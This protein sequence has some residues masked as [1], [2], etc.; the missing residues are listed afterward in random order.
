MPR[1]WRLG[2]YLVVIAAVFALLPGIN[3]VP[4]NFPAVTLWNFRIASLGI[5]TVLWGSI[6]IMFGY[7]GARR[8]R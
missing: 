4:T 5:Q 6:G 2:A 1:C 3:E 7:I 8:A